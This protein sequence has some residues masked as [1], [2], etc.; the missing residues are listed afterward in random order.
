MDIKNIKIRNFRG[1]GSLDWMVGGRFVCL[2][3]PGD[4]TKSTILDAIELALTPRRNV[5]FDDTDFFN[6]N[7]ADPII[8]EIT[9]GEIPTELLSEAKFGYW[10]RGWDGETIKDEPTDNDQPLLTIQ[11]TIDESLDP[12][13]LIVNDRRPEGKRISSFDRAKFGVSPIRD[14]SN[15][16]LSWGPGSVLTQLMEEHENNLSVLAEARRQAKASLNPDLLPTFKLSAQIAQII[17]GKLG[18]IAKSENGFVPHLDV[19]S[20]SIGSSI[21][22]LHDGS[23]P[24]R[25]SGLGSNRLLTLGLQHEACRSGGINLY[26]ALTRASRSVTILGKSPILNPE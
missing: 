14:Y 6:A 10:I 5:T 12:I 26:V 2:I 19:R 8:V 22:A 13:W 20:I 23:I 9:I 21:L 7:T 15:R 24:M 16:Q 3:G 1:I 18:V 11:L 4:S 17:G 25:N